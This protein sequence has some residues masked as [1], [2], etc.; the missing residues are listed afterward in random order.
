MK[1]ILKRIEYM[2]DMMDNRV[3]DINFLLNS[4]LDEIAIK[5]KKIKELEE[6]NNDLSTK[7]SYA[8]NDKD[9]YRKLVY[10]LAKENSKLKELN[11]NNKTRIEDLENKKNGINMASDY[12]K[13][14]HIKKSLK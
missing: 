14:A 6:C 13:F 2:I 12:F 3:E 5:D 7:L 9:D 10:S 4:A 1:T 8:V 11:K